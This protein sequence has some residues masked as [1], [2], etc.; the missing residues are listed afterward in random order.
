MQKGIVPRPEM[1]SDSIV[2]PW[3][4]AP[5][6]VSLNSNTLSFRESMP[7]SVFLL[8]SWTLILRS[9]IVSSCLHMTLA[10]SSSES[11]LPFSARMYQ[12]ASAMTGLWIL[13][14]PA[15]FPK[16]QLRTM[17]LNWSERR[18]QI[19][20]FCVKHIGG[21]YIKISLSKEYFIV[22][23]KQTFAMHSACACVTRTLERRKV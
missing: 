11:S 19:R 10:G 7:V 9:A 14:N 12:T 4:L 3:R 2:C 1:H 22:L 5:I 6:P 20:L 18:L 8:L 15:R 23:G 13:L 17:G 21:M 16:M